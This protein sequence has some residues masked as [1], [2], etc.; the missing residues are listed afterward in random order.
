MRWLGSGSCSLGSSVCGERKSCDSAQCL[1]ETEEGGEAVTV[2][3]CSS[4]PGSAVPALLPP[5]TPP[6]P[7]SAPHTPRLILTRTLQGEVLISY[8][9]TADSG[10]V[11]RGSR[12][13]HS[14]PTPPTDWWLFILE[15]SFCVR[16][17]GV[18]TVEVGDHLWPSDLPL[19]GF[20]ELKSGYWA[21]KCLCT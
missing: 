8:V 13:R 12:L 10:W 6:L 1:Q 2:S 17:G 18:G 7:T 21:C 15:H 14:D 19:C 9:R 3:H 20:Q 5:F 11:K 4:M 16:E